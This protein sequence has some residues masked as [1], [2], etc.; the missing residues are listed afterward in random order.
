MLN[1]H[2]SIVTEHNLLAD[3]RFKVAALRNHPQGWVSNLPVDVVL[4]IPVSEHQYTLGFEFVLNY[5]VT[6]A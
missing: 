3:R 6:D 5:V 4:Y 1:H 2:V